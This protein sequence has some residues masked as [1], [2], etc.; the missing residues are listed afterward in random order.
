MRPPSDCAPLLARSRAARGKRGRAECRRGARAIRAK[1][2]RA[3]P[4]AGAASRRSAIPRSSRCMP[5]G[6]RRFSCSSAWSHRRRSFADLALEPSP[7]AARTARS[8]RRGVR[9]LRGSRV[10]R[11][12]DAASQRRSPRRRRR[13]CAVGADARPRRARAARTRA[14]ARGTP[15][16]RPAGERRGSFVA[17]RLTNPR[18]AQFALKVT[19]AAMFCYIAYTAVDWSGIH[20]CM[21]TCIIV[22]L[23]ERRGDDPEVDAAP[24]RLRDR[25]QPRARS[26]VFLVPHMTSIAQLALLVAAVTAPAA[27]DRDGQRAHGVRGSADRI[28]LLPRR[29]CRDLHPA[30]CHRDARSLSSASFSAWS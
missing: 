29:R 23:G 6:S 21:I 15:G 18:H 9:A 14:A 26:I 11:R 19:L 27:L 3:A 17:E 30:R 7:R 16:S 8:R 13:R 10:L 2:V 5:S 1:G 24:H 12:R 25:R 22:A 20:T 4:Q 28:R